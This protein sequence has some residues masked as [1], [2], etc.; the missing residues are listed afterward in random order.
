MKTFN[1]GR[2]W[3]GYS[4]GRDA[5]SVEANTLEEALEKAEWMDGERSVTR[6]DTEADDWEEM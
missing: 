5:I 4:G 1:L 2:Q 6:D 3:G